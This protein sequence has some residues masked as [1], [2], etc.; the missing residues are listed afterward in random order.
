MR[1]NPEPRPR[2]IRLEPQSRPWNYCN[3][4]TI[5]RALFVIY[6]I[7]NYVVGGFALR[8]MVWRA[9]AR[10]HRRSRFAQINLARADVCPPG[11]FSLLNPPAHF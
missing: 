6:K 7:I 5:S 11:L 8:A 4:P 9:P 10:A 3:S 2:Q 1:G